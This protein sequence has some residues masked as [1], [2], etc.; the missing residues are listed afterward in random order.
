MTA[1]QI[2]QEIKEIKQLIVN[3]RFKKGFLKLAELIEEIDR[4]DT[5]DTDD[6]DLENQYLMI[7]SRFET[8]NSDTIKGAP[9]ASEEINQIKLS[10]LQFLDEVRNIAIEYS[11]DPSDEK[12][13]KYFVPPPDETVATAVPANTASTNANQSDDGFSYSGKE[14][15]KVKISNKFLV[16]SLSFLT[17]IILGVTWIIANSDACKK[18]PIIINP[19]PPGV[20]DSSDQVDPGEKPVALGPTGS[21]MKFKSGSA[22]YDL[23]DFLSNS[24]LSVP[25]KI[26]KIKEASFQRTK[27][28]LKIQPSEQL[29]KI[30]M[31]LEKYPNAQIDIYGYMEE[32]ETGGS[33]NKEVGLDAERANAFKKYLK[34]KGID[35]QMNIEEGGIVDGIDEKVR[36]GIRVI[37]RN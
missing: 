20:V 21:E 28:G 2:R 35:N 9:T 17:V 14:G 16:S 23:A 4:L 18:E 10:I 1:D 29:D 32:D 33:G 15:E 37:S 26:I 6:A 3:Q 27:S 36:I 34:G 24:E 31:V 19:I 25:S 30:A 8:I 22:E 12:T 13:A 11:V 5:T 7:K